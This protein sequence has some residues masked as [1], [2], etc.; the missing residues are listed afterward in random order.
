[1]KGEVPVDREEHVEVGLSL[2]SAD[3]RKVLEKLGKGSPASR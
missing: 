2:L 3:R 1:L